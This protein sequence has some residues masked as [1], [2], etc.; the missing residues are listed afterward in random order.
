MSWFEEQIKLRINSDEDA[1]HDVILEMAAALGSKRGSIIY[2]GSGT[3]V[4]NAIYPIIHFYKGTHKCKEIPEELTDI[5]EILD[6]VSSTT[7]I[8]YRD[9]RLDKGWSKR[10][11]GAMLGR[12]NDNDG[13]VSILRDPVG[14]YY[15]ISAETGEKIRITAVNESVIAKDAICFYRPLPKSAGKRSALWDYMKTSARMGD[16]FKII[17][18]ALLAT[19]L[20]LQIAPLTNIVYGNVLPLGELVPLAAI[21]VFCLAV[22]ISQSITDMLKEIMTGSCTTRQS[23]NLQAA[24]MMRVLSLPAPFF[25][26]Y[27]P[28]DLSSR[29]DLIPDFC[30]RIV[31]AFVIGIYAAAVSVIYIIQMFNYS[32]SMAVAVLIQVILV[33]MTFSICVKRISVSRVKYLEYKAK[34][35][36]LV[37]S[38]L[39]GIS[40]IRL[41]GSENRFF[42]QWGR[43]Y[44]NAVKAFFSPMIWVQMST[45]LPF[46]FSLITL[47]FIYYLAV[48]N[49][50]S[51][52]NYIG[53]TVSY[54]MVTGVLANLTASV[55][56]T[57]NIFPIY[58]MLRPILETEPENE[59]RNKDSAKLTGKIEVQNLTFAYSENGPRVID[60]LNLTIEKGQ[61]VAIVGSTG[62]GKTTLMRLLLGFETPLSG[63]VY[64][65]QKALKNLDLR[66]VRRQ[67]GTVLQDGKL[68]IGD[69]YSNI[70][71][72]NPRLSMSEAWNAAELAGI[73]DDI[74]KMP[75]Q[76]RTLISEENGGISGGQKQRLMIARAIANKPKILFFDEATS[77]LDN[78]S[79][80]KVSDSLNSLK[81]TRIVI[82]HRLST[83]KECDRILVMDKGK[84]IGD[85]NYETLLETCPFFNELVK[86]QKL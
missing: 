24:M 57:A 16:I 60:K 70:V 20:G 77:A 8:M 17:M 66:S 56:N 84:I 36:G 25:R 44:A 38:S 69:I 65:D 63:Q 47:G 41:S 67:I 40:K 58:E 55:E 61:Y 46:A 42:I 51:L 74:R 32:K 37:Y 3:I 75:M 73:A 26:S 83:I 21:L 33:V 30:T 11:F 9:V 14:N 6:F 35:N 62:C 54:G 18:Y 10:A 64:Y 31:N 12:L 43:I 48:V 79:Q 34:E 13:V 50:V 23:I 49:G 4:R 78:I 5:E 59:S 22:K 29:I 28:G 19:L 71:I 82:A 39:Q 52:E 1:L 7:G 15:Y 81:C 72:C 45:L 68:F 80:K 53:F 85:G 27:S 76:M 2:K 86:R